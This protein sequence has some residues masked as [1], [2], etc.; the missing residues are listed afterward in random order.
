MTSLAFIAIVL[1]VVLLVISTVKDQAIDIDP[2]G[3]N[4]GSWFYNASINNCQDGNG[5]VSG[6]STTM[7][8]TNTTIGAVADIPPWLPI[9]VITMIGVI[10]L[11]LIQVFRR[12]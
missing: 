8:A 11:G 2:C 12:Q 3:N 5:V 9:I 6:L 7:N 10:L 1:A 4:N